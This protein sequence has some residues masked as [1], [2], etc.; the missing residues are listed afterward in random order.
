MPEVFKDFQK[1]LPSIERKISAI[2]QDDIRVALI[3]TV[4]DCQEN[5]V[6]IDDGTGKV[7]I[8]FDTNVEAKSG[9]MIRVLGR[10]I[11][12]DEGVEIQGDALQDFNGLDMELMKRL[13]KLEK[14]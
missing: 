14:Q 1:R 13:E 11:P 7:N 8:T 10:V 9:D 12:M 5:R 3:G 6:V 4:I 2:K